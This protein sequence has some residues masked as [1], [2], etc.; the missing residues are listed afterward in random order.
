MK[1][2]KVDELIQADLY[3]SLDLKESLFQELVCLHFVSALCPLVIEETLCTN[4]PHLNNLVIWNYN[5]S[6][7]MNGG[8]LVI[9]LVGQK[10]RMFPNDLSSIDLDFIKDFSTGSR[11]IQTTN[12]K[13]KDNQ[14]PIMS[15]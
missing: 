3:L 13:N 11:R 15:I 10:R 2:N 12:T 7:K 6:K 14:S 1:L 4:G 8:F 9:S 5:S